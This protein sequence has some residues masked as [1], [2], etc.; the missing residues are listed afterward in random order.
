MIYFVF[1]NVFLNKWEK[2]FKIWLDT[3]VLFSQI[4]NKIQQ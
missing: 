3:K 1:V 2:M 4:S